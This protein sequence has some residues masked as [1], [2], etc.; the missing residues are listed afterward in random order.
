MSEEASP[1]REITVTASDGHKT[2]V[3]MREPPGRGPFPALIELHGGLVQVHMEALK[4]GS[5]SI[6]N[7]RFLAAGYVTVVATFRD[8]DVDPMSPG[9][10]MD[11]TALV[12]YVRKLPEVDPRSVVIFGTSGGGALALDLAIEVSPAAVI[13]HEPA[14]PVFTGIF[15]AQTPKRGEK[16]TPTGAEIT[17]IVNNYER[18]WTPERQAFTR[19]K[20]SKIH[21]P[22]F[23][24]EGGVI[25]ADRFINE[26]LIPEMMNAGIDLQVILYPGQPHSFPYPN[27]WA[28]TSS[29]PALKYFRDAAA[30]CLPHLATKPKP[31]AES[32]VTYAPLEP[33]PYQRG[34]QST[35]DGKE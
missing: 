32:L 20:L 21:C 8:R 27:D 25:K 33:R 10:L 17:P 35:E 34:G 24:P 14:W 31:I 1:L 22:I 11:T 23:I 3:V 2:T 9:P 4:N 28:T 29:G 5:R 19:Q 16:F 12:E 6:T 18:A 30:F 15:N 26:V 7:S 13:A